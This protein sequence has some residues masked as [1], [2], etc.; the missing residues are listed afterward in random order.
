MRVGEIIPRLKGWV[1]KIFSKNKDKGVG[2]FS[3]TP[4]PIPPIRDAFAG[5]MSA[6][7]IGLDKDK[8]DAESMKINCCHWQR[9]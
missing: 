9:F 4:K 3:P 7:K 5:P 1:R 6:V 8:A 2:G